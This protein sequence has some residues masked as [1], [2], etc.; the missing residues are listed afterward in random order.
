[1]NNLDM[2]G[3]ETSNP[4]KACA[5]HPVQDNISMSCISEVVITLSSVDKW[6][7]EMTPTQKELFLGKD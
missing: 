5:S 3:N 4:P 1:M 7:N 2:D 6:S